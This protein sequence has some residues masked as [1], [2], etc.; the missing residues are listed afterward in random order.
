[1]NVSICA[2]N[3]TPEST[4]LHRRSR[5]FLAGTTTYADGSPLLLQIRL[6]QKALKKKC[7]FPTH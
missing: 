6:T 3:G 4:G 7:G 5:W 2:P 1:M